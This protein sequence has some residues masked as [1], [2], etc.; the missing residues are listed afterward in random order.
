[1]SWNGSSLSAAFGDDL[2]VDNHTVGLRAKDNAGNWSAVTT[3]TLTVQDTSPPIISHVLSAQ[4]N[5]N[6]WYRSPFTIT[7]NISDNESPIT[8]S[9][10]C[11][12]TTVNSN[13]PASGTTYTCTA[14]SAGGTSSDAVTVKYDAT[15]PTLG[16][17]NWSANPLNV[18]SNT[19]LTQPASD[20]LSGID[21]SEY[22]VDTD[23]GQGN[24]TSL[25]LVNGNLSATFG[26]NLSLGTHTVGIRTRDKAGNW[27]T[28][29]EQ[30]IVRD[31]TPPTVGHILSLQPNV[32]GWYKT[33]VVIDWQ[34]TDPPPSSGTPSDPPNT[35]AS[36]QGANVTYTSAQSCDPAGNCATGSVQLSIDK[37]IPTVSNPMAPAVKFRNQTATVSATA[38]DA[39]SGVWNGE[40]YLD[41]DPGQGN[42]TAMTLSGSTIS[43]TI[44]TNVASGMHT[45]FI[46]SRDRAGNWSTTVSRTIFVLPI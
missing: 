19:T 25:S 17:A 15:P 34:A 4:P 40:F 23:P 33:D 29:I 37:T 38:T 8:S 45:I 41:T 20:S 28:K 12:V 21:Y 10:G 24:A 46:R 36:T 14:T 1:M 44:G 43:G 26:S 7:W 30:L 18:G 3:T 13:T 2:P 42:G 6:G 5:G 22:Y 16:A 27:T 35:T 9:T 11:D 32:N 31:V 39:L